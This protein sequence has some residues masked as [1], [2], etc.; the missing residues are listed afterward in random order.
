MASNLQ[1][2]DKVKCARSLYI[3]NNIIVSIVF[4]MYIYIIEIMKNYK[5]ENFEIDIKDYYRSKFL[6][7]K[8]V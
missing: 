5:S 1:T 6:T 2:A 7:I 3:T 4:F 8:F